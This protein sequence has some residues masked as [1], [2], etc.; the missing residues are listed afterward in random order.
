MT[1]ERE[2]GASAQMRQAMDRLNA[3][4][5]AAV[6]HVD[7]PLL[8]VA[9][10]G[11]GKTQ[12]LSLR[13]A[14]ILASRDVE[15]KNILCLTFGNAG[16][17]AMRKRLVELIGRAA[18]GIEVSTF[19]SFAAS[20]RQRWPEFFE[21]GGTSQ[22]VSD[23]R[24][25]EIVNRILNALPPS[26][27]LASGQAGGVN[28]RL[29]DILAFIG[30][31]KRSGLTTD[32]LRAI[33]RQT[34]QFIDHAEADEG[35]MALVNAG[36]PRAAQAKEAFC[37]DFETAVMRVCSLAPAHLREPVVSTPGMYVPYATW[38]GRLVGAAELI[39]EDGKTGGLKDVRDALFCG[40]AKD[41]RSFKDRVVAE[42]ALAA[43]DVFDAYEEALAAEGLYDYDDMILEAIQ[44]IQAHPELQQQLLDRYLYVQ[45]DEFQ[46][47]N[48]AQMRILEL[49]AKDAASPNIMAVCDDDQAIMRFQGATIEC[50]QQF[51]ERWHPTS[52]VLKTNYRS[53][54]A[55]VE[56]GKGVA[57]Q[58]ETRLPT[59]ATDKDI[60]AFRPAG[61]QTSFCE[62]VFVSK[63]AE[64]YALAEAIRQAIDAGFIEGSED[65]SE[66]IAVIAP[67]HASLK[68]LIPYLNAF[69][70]PF[71]YR[72]TSN[73]FQMES[74]QTLLA[75]MRYAAFA[76]AG[77][78]ERAAAQLPQIVAARE[79]GRSS[80]A[81]VAFAAR[82]KRDHHGD[83]ARALA[84]EGGKLHERLCDWAAAAASAPVRELIHAM[85][86]GIAAHYVAEADSD[87]WALAEFHAGIRAL[88]AFA[89]AEIASS[90][91]L[92]RAVRL[93]D[94]VERMDELERYKVS[95]DATIAL[96]R[97]DA[98]RLVSAH[99]SKGLEFDRVYLLD[100]DDD[101][102]HKGASSSAL[103]TANMLVGASKDDDDARRLLFVA[104]TRAKQEMELFRAQGRT[105]RELQGEIST[106]EVE[107]TAQEAATIIQVSWEARYAADTPEFASLLVPD[108]V[109]RSLS[110]SALND[111]VE[112][113]D[114]AVNSLEYP[115]KR[116]LRLPRSPEPASEF[117]TLVH[118]F[119]QDLV[120]KCGSGAC[121]D[122]CC[123]T[124]GQ[125]ADA[126]RAQLSWMDFRPDEVASLVR[127]FDRV[128]ASFVPW[129]LEHLEGRVALEAKM[130]TATESGVP[131]FGIADLLMI[132][133]AAQRVRVFDYK[134]GFTYPGKTPT[135]A[136]ER[137]LQFYKLLIE[138]S[139]EYAGYTVSEGIDLYVE[140]ERGTE[141][142]LH[143]PVTSLVG[144]GELEHLQRLIDVVWRRISDGDFDTSAFESSPQKADAV[145][146]NVTAKGEPRKR[147]DHRLIQEAYED[148]LIEQG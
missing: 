54:P 36:I 120:G 136:Y 49:L 127:R 29:G 27:T 70:V 63:D 47:T 31:F 44:A 74:M 56:L 84:E 101:T 110:A 139:P 45:V 95:V 42:R 147:M 83:W 55:I 50:I 60:Q 19:H 12:L 131:L 114:G 122:G 75:L 106:E 90:S 148:W 21:R 7:G 88:L 121:P 14:N 72:E 80:E 86:K 57:S 93:T 41:G 130:E 64:R 117:G 81:C 58:I 137:Q 66:A 85:A 91:S 145:A 11:T 38:L 30:H 33:M 119:L 124:V 146:R 98:V 135:T 32:E 23:L 113:H 62:H 15:P 37:A 138:G 71:S 4:Q 123:D 69:D 1:Q 105:L 132:D 2:D 67:K 39:D 97:G 89:E 108:L 103:F 9:G 6:D 96:G 3:E 17:E 143:E 28:T 116:M 79:Y 102:W 134:T 73:V 25:S 10:P 115:A 112:Y 16:A 126:Y 144:A 82:A 13:A 133:D 118:A 125:L 68:E 18:Y 78:T 140:P 48:G 22:L 24:K 46:D 34:I 5:R 51:Q 65:P 141:G 26:S 35:L 53:T 109:P 107:P 104:L 77:R 111:F 59:S 100:A 129:L 61:E 87:P 142:E 94:V 92:G 8:V 20:V 99:G 76:A 40:T 52:I 128:V 43:A